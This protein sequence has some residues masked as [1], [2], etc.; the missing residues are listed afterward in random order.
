MSKTRGLHRWREQQEEQEAAF[1]AV[2]PCYTHFT[3]DGDASA[4]GSVGSPV[5]PGAG[6]DGGLDELYGAT[7][8]AL[9]APTAFGPR[10][11]PA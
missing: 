2:S 11:P 8:E 1:R 6:A 7:L 3:E 4:S 5:M 9:D 10:A